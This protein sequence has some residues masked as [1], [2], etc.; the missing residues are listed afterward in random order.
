MSL[1]Q[2]CILI[3]GNRSLLTKSAAVFRVMA[4][5]CCHHCS[6]LQIRCTTDCC[7]SSPMWEMSHLLCSSW[8]VCVSVRLCLSVFQNLYACMCIGM[9]VHVVSCPYNCH[10]KYFCVFRKS[11]ESLQ[12]TGWDLYNYPREM[13]RQ[14]VSPST[15]IHDRQPHCS[16]N[17]VCDIVSSSLKLVLTVF[18]HHYGDI[19]VLNFFLYYKAYLIRPITLRAIRSDK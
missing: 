5:C 16:Y 7:I 8:S 19:C 17:Y 11:S 4:T 9:C 18:L 1:T 10:K 12:L 15:S 2:V 14:K 13:D 3:W 6:T